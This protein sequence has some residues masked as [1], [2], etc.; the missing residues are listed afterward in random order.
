MPHGRVS[1]SS[2]QQNT[3]KRMRSPTDV[4]SASWSRSHFG[5]RRCA[6]PLRAM[7]TSGNLAGRQTYRSVAIRALC[8]GG[9]HHRRL[10]YDPLRWFGRI[11]EADGD[12]RCVGIPKRISAS[13]SKPAFHDVM[14]GKRIAQPRP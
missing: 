8:I 11:V 12:V 1:V 4:I 3:A 7:L 2:E 6:M 13:A 10:F 9:F 5:S 14:T